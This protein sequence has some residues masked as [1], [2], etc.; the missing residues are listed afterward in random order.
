VAAHAKVTTLLK[1]M[2]ARRATRDRIGSRR[3]ARRQTSER[4]YVDDRDRT[5]PA[6][7]VPEKISAVRH[8]A[9]AKVGAAANEDA[10]EVATSMRVYDGTRLMPGFPSFPRL[11]DITPIDDENEAIRSIPL[12]WIAGTWV[13]RRC[14]RERFRLCCALGRY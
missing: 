3:V 10:V 8:A 14:R 13:E 11:A 7:V 2:T 4:G 9:A 5:I 1:K 12:V 6:S